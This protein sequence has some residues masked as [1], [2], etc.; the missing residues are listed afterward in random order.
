MRRVVAVLAVVLAALVAS[1]AAS[2]GSTARP[3]VTFFGDSVAAALA[4]EKKARTLLAKGLDLQ[5]D[6][7]VCRRLAETGCPYKGERPSSVLS[8]VEKPARPLGSVVVIDVGYN[9]VPADYG[10]DLDRVMQVLVRQGVSTVIWVTMQENRPLYRTTNAE[11]VSAARRWPQIRIADWHEASKTKAT[12]FGDDGLH[13]SSQGAMGLARFL[14][15]LVLASSCTAACL[16]AK[17]ASEG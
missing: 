2:A 1:S 7:K 9:D 12:W 5:F 8:L 17:R 4:Y 15:P 13:L 10:A 11:I 6:A 16:R 14:R 3:R